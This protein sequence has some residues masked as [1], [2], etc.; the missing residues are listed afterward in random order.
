M[1]LAVFTEQNLQFL[2]A[3]CTL[4]SRGVTATLILSETA[5]LLALVCFTGRGPALY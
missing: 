3:V 1:T 2:V 5:F 4:A